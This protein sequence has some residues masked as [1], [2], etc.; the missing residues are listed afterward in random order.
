MGSFQDLC[1]MLWPSTMLL[2][3]S[4]LDE[5]L[6]LTWWFQELSFYTNWSVINKMYCTLMTIKYV[7]VTLVFCLRF[8]IIALFNLYLCFSGFKE[9]TWLWERTWDARWSLIIG[10][11]PYKYYI[12]VP[13]GIDHLSV[14]VELETK[15]FFITLSHE[16]DDSSNVTFLLWGNLSKLEACVVY[17]L[18]NSRF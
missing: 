9:N 5:P 7:I 14:H 2:L 11:G 12:N 18:Y 1:L 16:M 8:I 10:K 15:S 6:L 17:F 4:K 13:V 3:E